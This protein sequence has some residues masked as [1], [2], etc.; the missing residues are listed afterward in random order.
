M[1]HSLRGRLFVGLMLMIVAT[2][3]GGGTFA[4]RWS[5][6]EAIEMQ[7]SILT[8]VGALALSTRF[9]TDMP[10]SSS[11]DAEARVVIEELGNSAS[12]TPDARALW[13]LPDG[14]H[15]AS[16]GR[17]PWRIL[18][19]TRPDGSRIAVGQPTAIRD[20]IARDSAVHTILPFAALIPCLMLVVA[21]VIG[22]SLQPMVRLAGH[23]D[24]RRADDLDRLPLEG[25][26]SELHPFIASIN[27]L[28]D[29]IQA[30]MDQQQRFV[31]D[32]AHELRTPITALSLQAENLGQVD[33]PEE[34]RLRLAVLKDGTRRTKHLLDQL[35][36]LARYDA[37]RP[38]DIGDTALDRCAKDVVADMLPDA[39]SRGIDLGFTVVESV[40]TRG[41]PIMIAAV[42][43]NLIDNALRFTPREGRIDVGVCHRGK[44]AILQVED[45]GPGIAPGDLDHIFE[46]F[47]RGS[48]PAGDGTGLGL[49]I[50]KR[51]VDRLGGSVALENVSGA[52]SS[53]LR[54]T[55]RLPAVE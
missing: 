3:V 5:F 52:G 6:D 22:Q 1:T 30:M 48:R 2:G 51:I 43:R 8:Q 39:A 40:S 17:E 32:A 26:P 19:R 35:L 37:T 24:T 36:A 45:T 11:V 12:G 33:L 41:E 23:L 29:R 14:L 4:F 50:V 42:I 18:L 13:A 47:F 15:I 10:V 25:T 53:G 27:R 46:P 54:A 44:E 20:E 16:R 9:Q 28:L 55:V 7:D 49:S 21:V 34:G 38:P 31:A